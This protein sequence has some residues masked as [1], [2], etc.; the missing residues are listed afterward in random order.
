[1]KI[2][3]YPFC[4]HISFSQIISDYGFRGHKIY[5]HSS[6]GGL[7]PNKL[8]DIFPWE[9]FFKGTQVRYLNKEELKINYEKLIDPLFSIWE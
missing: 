3:N 2:I 5:S 4:I 6:F 9:G 1:M 7:F 8:E